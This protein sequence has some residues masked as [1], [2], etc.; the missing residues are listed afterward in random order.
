MV[1]FSERVA[2][3]AQKVQFK[4]RHIWSSIHALTS[5]RREHGVQPPNGATIATT[6]SP[7]RSSF[8]AETNSLRSA[9]GVNFMAKHQD[10]S[11]S[12][13]R[14]ITSLTTLLSLIYSIWKT[15]LFYMSLTRLRRS[16]RAS[17]RPSGIHCT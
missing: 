4:S 7:I 12:H 16:M 1:L 8:G 5:T 3:N 17:S 13:S 6:A 11:S 9:N 15:A 10:D 14:M 2:P